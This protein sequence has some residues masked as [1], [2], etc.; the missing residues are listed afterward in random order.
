MNAGSKDTPPPINGAWRRLQDALALRAPSGLLKDPL[1]L[2]ALVVALPVAWGLARFFEPPGALAGWPLLR[3]MGLDP[4]VE[5]L[6]FRG[7]IQGAFLKTSAGRTARAGF[8]LANAGTAL[9]FAAVHML[10]HPPIW[11]ALVLVPAL[12]FGFFRDRFGSV[13]PPILL[14]VFYNACWLLA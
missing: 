10:Y 8:T 5:E 9:L 12:V 6:L 13:A 14:H 2:L 7:L 11:A 3:L 1:F 4:L